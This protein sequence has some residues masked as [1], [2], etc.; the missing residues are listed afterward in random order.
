M[1]EHEI[2]IFCIGILVGWLR[3]FEAELKGEAAKG[4][5]KVLNALDAQRKRDA[6]RVRQFNERF[7]MQERMDRI[8]ER[9]GCLGLILIVALV[10]SWAVYLRLHPVVAMASP[11]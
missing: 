3:E 11:P 4:W 8:I 9:L 5:P 10:V 7:D 6:E 2:T 1:N